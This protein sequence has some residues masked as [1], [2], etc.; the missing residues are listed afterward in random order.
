MTMDAE[1]AAPRGLAGHNY[2]HLPIE[3]ALVRFRSVRRSLPTVP[4]PR[5]ALQPG[6]RGLRTLLD[7]VVEEGLEGEEEGALASYDVQSLFLQATEGMADGS[8]AEQYG[9]S[10]VTT[11]SSESPP[12]TTSDAAMTDA[13]VIGSKNNSSSSSN[14]GPWFYFANHPALQ[15]EG[16]PK[17]DK[18]I[19]VA[20]PHIQAC[21]VC[22]LSSPES[23]AKGGNIDGPGA[24]SCR[25]DEACDA[26]AEKEQRGAAAALE[27]QPEFTRMWVTDRG[28]ALP[29]TTVAT[30]FL[31]SAFTPGRTDAGQGDYT[32]VSEQQVAAAFNAT[33]RELGL[34][35]RF[36][37]RV[38][39]AMTQES[40]D[41]MFKGP[42]VP[43]Y[44]KEGSG[45]PARRRL[46]AMRAAQRRR[47]Q[48]EMGEVVGQQECG[49]NEL[50]KAYIVSDWK[51]VTDAVA[52][53]IR[54]SEAEAV[55]TAELQARA[56]E[57]A[58][59]GR[60]PVDFADDENRA[61]KWELHDDE[62]GAS[63][64][65]AEADGP[66]ASPPAICTLV[67]YRTASLHVP[68]TTKAGV[69]QGACRWCLIEN[70]NAFTTA[71]LSSLAAAPPTHT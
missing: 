55:L 64:A 59:A 46:K 53:A 14:S 9:G 62:V 29:N 17:T 25:V 60:S 71:R 63:T 20:S 34:P 11:G 39:R 67:A 23:S 26:E 37:L 19:Y 12:T 15:V 69:S 38:E 52:R 45:E 51:N 10:A 47:L 33:V 8:L 44:L 16:T 32:T 49:R 61:E 4:M 57:D 5:S 6:R 21:S 41:P 13:A 42:D 30:V 22:G 70:G 66:P 31:K 28:A 43:E 36:H 40:I 50:F 54:S 2:N 7:D 65:A 56:E 48:E 24:G 68:S 35:T 3:D 58:A 1:A 18:I 27:D